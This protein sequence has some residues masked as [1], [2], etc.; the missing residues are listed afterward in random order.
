[1]TAKKYIDRY[2]KK[3]CASQFS[4]DMTQNKELI[5]LL[6]SSPFHTACRSNILKLGLEYY[7]GLLLAAQI[8]S[9]CYWQYRF[10]MYSICY[11]N[12]TVSGRIK[13][14]AIKGWYSK[15]YD[16]DAGLNWFKNLYIRNFVHQEAL[17]RYSDLNNGENPHWHLAKLYCG[18]P[19]KNDITSKKLDVIMKEEPGLSLMDYINNS[20]FFTNQPSTFLHS[21]ALYLNCETST[22]IRN[23]NSEDLCNALWKCYLNG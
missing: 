2:V 11:Q 19:F 18:Y 15:N 14:K 4:E 9:N 17:L 8:P 10:E 21:V 23:L 7:S 1:M 6:Y 5:H 20:T 13:A 22:K 3:H 12:K 16:L